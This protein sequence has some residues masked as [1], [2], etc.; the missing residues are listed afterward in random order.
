MDIYVHVNTEELLNEMH[1]FCDNFNKHKEHMMSFFTFVFILY[2]YI[3][4]KC[5]KKKNVRVLA[6]IGVLC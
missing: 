3:Y 6:V 5:K 4:I 2:R 1:L